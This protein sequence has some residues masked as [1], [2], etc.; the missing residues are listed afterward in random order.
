[1]SYTHQRYGET[2]IETEYLIL[3]RRTSG[4]I[5]VQDKTTGKLVPVQGVRVEQLLKILADMDHVLEI[6]IREILN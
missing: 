1:M 6:S 2:Y 3:I 5:E 4:K